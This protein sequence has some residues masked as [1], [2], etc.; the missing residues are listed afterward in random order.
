M[1]QQVAD[2]HLARD[3]RIVHLKSGQMIDHLVIPADSAAI[4]ED[5]QRSDRKGLA[6]RACRE[7][8]IGVHRVGLAED[9]EPKP[10]AKVTLSFST[11]A[12]A[13]PGTPISR[14]TDSTRCSSPLEARIDQHRR[15]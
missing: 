13:M 1:N 2:G 6:G 12:M 14:R 15:R 10:F 8:R 3:P 4:D 9:F 5:C 7:D 11:M